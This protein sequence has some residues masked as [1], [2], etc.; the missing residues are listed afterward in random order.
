M[1]LPASYQRKNQIHLLKLTYCTKPIKKIHVHLLR[2]EKSCCLSCCPV[3]I[4]LSDSETA[5]GLVRGVDF[6]LNLKN[7]AMLFITKYLKSSEAESSSS[8]LNWYICHAVKP[9]KG[10]ILFMCEWGPISVF[11]VFFLDWVQICNLW[12]FTLSLLTLAFHKRHLVICKA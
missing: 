7:Y 6:R 3:S 5:A 2:K 8:F 10:E 4:H 9:S 11:T 12:N 1:V